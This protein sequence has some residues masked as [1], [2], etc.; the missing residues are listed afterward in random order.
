MSTIN[1]KT[2]VEEVFE[3]MHGPK[4]DI[5]AQ[6]CKHR[7]LIWFRPLKK[8]PSFL[9]RLVSE[10]TRKMDWDAFEPGT[11]PV[12]SIHAGSI[13]SFKE[14][15]HQNTG[16]R[17]VDAVV[18]GSTTESGLE[19]VIAIVQSMN[20][21]NLVKM[22]LSED[23][24]WK[25]ML[26]LPLKGLLSYDSWLEPEPLDPEYEPIDQR[27]ESEYG[28]EVRRP[29]DSVES[30]LLSASLDEVEALRLLVRIMSRKS[31]RK[32]R[33]PAGELRCWDLLR[34]AR[35]LQEFGS[36]KEAGVVA[37]A[38]LEELLIPLSQLTHEEVR[39]DRIMF[40]KIISL[41]ERHKKLHPNETAILREFAEMRSACAHAINTQARPD[42]NLAPQVDSFINW[43][44][45]YP[46]WLK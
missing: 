32:A 17:E 45:T 18:L 15:A 4:K 40:G 34:Y 24:I 8:D 21:D 37:G 12:I 6:L 7:I 46:D 23:V 13:Y 9:M 14:F 5:G 22:D 3:S 36:V 28:F 39:R 16:I 43:L 10:L 11:T 35:E 27:H 1:V 42:D 26:I 19:S 20:L 33:Q 44:E 29:R 30:D 38:A 2:L 41:V 25:A 31:E